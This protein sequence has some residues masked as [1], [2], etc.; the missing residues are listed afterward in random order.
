MPQALSSQAALQ[1]QNHV[2]SALAEFAVDSSSTVPA[3]AQQAVF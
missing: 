3:T 2:E 1:V